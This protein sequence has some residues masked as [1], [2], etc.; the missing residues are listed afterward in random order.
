MATRANLPPITS[1]HKI[2]HISRPAPRPALTRAPACR[3]GRG[4]SLGVLPLN[5]AAGVRR[6]GAGEDW[7]WK[8]QPHNTTN[9]TDWLVLAPRSAGVGWMGW[10]GTHKMVAA[11]W[12]GAGPVDTDTAQQFISSHTSTRHQTLVHRC[13]RRQISRYLDIYTASPR[14]LLQCYTAACSLVY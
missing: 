10:D 1:L 7:Q 3:R 2:T 4:G 5:K 11:V 6:L 8:L 9:R 13:R 14:S 12:G